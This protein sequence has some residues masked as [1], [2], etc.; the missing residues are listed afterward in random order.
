MDGSYA[1][2]VAYERLAFP[3]LSMT[4]AWQVCTIGF[5]CFS[6]SSLIVLILDVDSWEPT[7]ILG[8]LRSMRLL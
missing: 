3:S 7:K 5:P 8:I 6:N 1:E 4:A 2:W